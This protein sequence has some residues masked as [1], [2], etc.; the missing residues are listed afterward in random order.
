MV[1][2]LINDVSIACINQ[3]AIA[4]HVSASMII[5]ILKIEG[6]RNGVKSRNKDG[7]YDYGPMQINSR[8]LSVVV[9]YGYTEHDLQY[10]PCINVAVGT[11]ILANNMA[12]GKTVWSGVGD[13]H[14]HNPVLNQNYRQ[15]VRYFHSWLVKTIHSHER[16]TITTS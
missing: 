8:W 15:K 4:Y 10:N 11:W 5:S 14:S 3:A 6:G 7:S 1:P 16:K 13:Y 12:K 9:P 2:F